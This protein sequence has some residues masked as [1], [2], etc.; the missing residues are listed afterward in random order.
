MSSGISRRFS[1]GGRGF[2]SHSMQNELHR[3]FTTPVVSG[4]ET[5]I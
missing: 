1:C 2:I 5:E 4:W 3:K